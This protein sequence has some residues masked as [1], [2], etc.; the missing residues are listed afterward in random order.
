MLHSNIVHRKSNWKI[1]RDV[2]N[3]SKWYFNKIILSTY[4]VAWAKLSKSEGE[5]GTRLMTSFLPSV[6]PIP[7]EINDLTDTTSD[8][9][10]K[11]VTG[12]SEQVNEPRLGEGGR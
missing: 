12:M 5:V 10:R 7:I 6:E 8:S 11:E 1:P 9:G 4:G 3:Y 2:L